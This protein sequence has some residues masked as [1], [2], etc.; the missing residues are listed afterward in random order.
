LSATRNPGFKILPRIGN[1]IRNAVFRL[2][3]NHG[4]Q[5]Y[6]RRF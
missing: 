5:T 6:F 1:T 4:E 3:Q 2:A